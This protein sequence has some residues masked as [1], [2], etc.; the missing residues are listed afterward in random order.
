MRK[1]KV[2]LV[3]GVA[4]FLVGCGQVAPAPATATTALTNTPACATGSVYSV[5]YGCLPQGGCGT[6]YGL[7]N[8]NCVLLGTTSTSSINGCYSVTQPIPFSGTSLQ[9]DSAGDI[10]GGNIPSYSNYG[11]MTVGTTTTATGTVYSGAANGTSGTFQMTVQSA[12]GGYVSNN[13][14]TVSG[15][16][17]LNA[18]GQQQALGA[19]TNSGYGTTTSGVSACI[20]GIAILGRLY[21]SGGSFF[22]GTVFLFMN[23]T[24]HGVEIGF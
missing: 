13:L 19:V 15:T 8:G 1:I 12:L 9:V 3:L 2:I 22:T 14:T 20:S 17:T 18:S 21:T 5:S 4:S 23:G 6:G 10:Y 7:Y 16:L 24:Q 11:T